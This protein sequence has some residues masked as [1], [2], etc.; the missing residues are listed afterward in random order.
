[1]HHARGMQCLG[2]PGL[3]GKG[4]RLLRRAPKQQ[5]LGKPC[6]R[7]LLPVWFSAAPG[8]RSLDDP[9]G[10]FQCLN[11]FVNLIAGTTFLGAMDKGSYSV[12]DA[13]VGRKEAATFGV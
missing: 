6:C 11:P 7:E 3:R 9:S 4:W 1:M 8:T 2:Q 12:T 5:F 10:R 13:A